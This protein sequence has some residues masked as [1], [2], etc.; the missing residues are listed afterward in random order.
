MA[1]IKCSVRI[2]GLISIKIQK[3]KQIYNK[4]KPVRKPG[5]Q[6]SKPKVFKNHG[7]L[8]AIDSSRSL[9]YSGFSFLFN[10]GDIL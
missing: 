2:N 5:T 4:G 1:D 3:K 10:E 6:S 7:S 8:A 9:K